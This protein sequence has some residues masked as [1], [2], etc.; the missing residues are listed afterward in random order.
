MWPVR[1]GFW[2]RNVGLNMICQTYFRK[3][4][5]KNRTLRYEPSP[6]FLQLPVVTL[7]LSH[8]SCTWTLL[9]WFVE[10][11]VSGLQLRTTIILKLINILSHLKTM[12]NTNL[13]RQFWYYLVNCRVLCMIRS[14]HN[15]TYYGLFTY[16]I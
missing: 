7:N 16:D 3:K 6:L 5:S 14:L 9:I 1:Q 4:N 8:L 15:M 10:F 11:T 13:R 2:N 12:I